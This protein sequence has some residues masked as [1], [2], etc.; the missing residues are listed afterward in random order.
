MGFNSKYVF[1]A[2]PFR[3]NGNYSIAENEVVGHQKDN[4]KMMK[5]TM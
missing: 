3:F 1:T 4:V 5:I 2:E